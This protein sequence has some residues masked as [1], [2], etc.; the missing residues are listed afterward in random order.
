MKLKILKT[1]LDLNTHEYHEAGSVKEFSDRRADEIVGK[2]GAG[3]VEKVV[4]PK[5][6]VIKTGK[7]KDEEIKD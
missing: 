3:F 5:N 2:L 4:T 6:K 7:A 1:F